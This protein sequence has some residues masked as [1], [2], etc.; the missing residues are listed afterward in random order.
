V[1][2][3]VNSSD[4]VI[5]PVLAHPGAR[6]NA[7]VGERGGALRVAVSAPPDKGKA[8]AAIQVVLAEGLGCKPACIK[9]VAGATSRQ[10]RFVIEGMTAP[11]LRERLGEILPDARRACPD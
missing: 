5:L 2:A 8:N 10:K 7:I 11:Q 9:L 1:I 3:L 4:G 6:R